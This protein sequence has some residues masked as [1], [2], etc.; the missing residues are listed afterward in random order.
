VALSDEDFRQANVKASQTIELESFTDASEIAPEYHETPYYL[1][2]AK[3]GEKGYSLLRE[4]LRKT[5][6]VG[7][8]TLVMRGR[9]HLCMIT[10]E[11][12]ALMLITLRFADEIKSDDDLDLPATSAR[13]AKVSPREVAMAERLVADMSAP[14]RPDHYH[15]TYREDL[16][17]RIQ[18]KVRKNQTHVLTPKEKAPREARPSA[19]VIDL[20]SVLKQ[21]LESRNGKGSGRQAARAATHRRGP[22]RASSP[23]RRQ[24]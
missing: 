10:G 17:S 2:P 11:Q 20:M 9:Q 14:W 22:K 13:S 18:E 15:D 5:R 16:M 12:R 19:Q 4:T 21:S 6:R 8:G 3:G 23:R 1:T 7:L 24:A